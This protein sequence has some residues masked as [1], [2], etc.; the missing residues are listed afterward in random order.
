MDIIAVEIKINVNGSTYPSSNLWRSVISE[1]EIYEGEICEDRYDKG[2]E[3]GKQ[4]CINNPEACGCIGGYTQS[5]LDNARQEGYNSGCNDCSNGSSSPATISPELNL[6]IPVL[7][8]Q[9]PFG[10]MDLWADFEFAGESDGDM[11][12][13]LSDFGQK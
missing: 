3:A 9:S 13:K 8:Y 10:A 6:H 4:Y 2:F 5:D 1:V 12:W 7:Q 11:L